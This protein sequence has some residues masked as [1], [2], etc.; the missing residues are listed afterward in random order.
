MAL[1]VA[2]GCSQRVGIE[3]QIGSIGTGP[4]AGGWEVEFWHESVSDDLAQPADDTQRGEREDHP[5]GNAA[6]LV[7]LK[8]GEEPGADAGADDGGC[9]AGEDDPDGH[10]PCRCLAPCETAK[11]SVVGELDEVAEGLRERLGGDDAESIHWRVDIEGVEQGAG[12]TGEELGAGDDAA[13]AHGGDRLAH[14]EL[15][16]LRHDAGEPRQRADEH[17]H[18]GRVRNER[19]EREQDDDQRRASD[20]GRHHRP[21]HVLPE[22]HEPSTVRRRLHGAVQ[23]HRPRHGKRGDK[24]RHEDDAPGHAE[25]AGDGWMSPARRR[26]FQRRVSGSCRVELLARQRGPLR[27]GVCPVGAVVE[28]GDEGQAVAASFAKDRLALHAQFLEGFEVVGNE[29]RAGDGRDVARRFWRVRRGVPPC[30][31]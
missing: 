30:R 18:D 28:A 17:Q 2:N 16:G 3:S 8:A 20:V 12:G 14:V 7:V 24:H 1:G 6:E 23:H 11:R 21:H 15:A 5:P 26:G 29:G 13:A 31:A 25:N 4:S 19:G 22:E 9:H 27:Q 10:G